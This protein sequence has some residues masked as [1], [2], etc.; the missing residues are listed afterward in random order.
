MGEPLLNR[1]R[2]HLISPRVKGGPLAPR[3]TA[4]GTTEPD[5]EE[6]EGAYEAIGGEG[7]ENVAYL[8]LPRLSEQLSR[9]SGETIICETP[10]RKPV[11]PSGRGSVDYRTPIKEG[12]QGTGEVRTPFYTP[13]LS[14]FDELAVALDNKAA[15]DLG[16]LLESRE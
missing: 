14:N 13:Y 8:V 16:V 4:T 5:S 3:T 9:Q 1:W 10:R 11:P 12:G 15:R 7:E 2:D 6:E